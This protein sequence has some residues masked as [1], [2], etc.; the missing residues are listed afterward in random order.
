MK[1]NTEAAVEV[2]ISCGLA[3]GLPHWARFT[4]SKLQLLG[5]PW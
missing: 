1:V 5:A 2:F 3:A 4:P